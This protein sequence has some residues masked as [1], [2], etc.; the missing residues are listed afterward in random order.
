MDAD[1]LS[2]YELRRCP[3]SAWPDA[4][5]RRATGLDLYVA[6]GARMGS[7]TW[8]GANM[9]SDRPESHLTAGENQPAY[10]FCGLYGIVASRRG[11]H[12]ARV[13]VSERRHGGG[14]RLLPR[15]TLAISGHRNGR[16]AW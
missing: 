15:G 7:R 16:R 1:L 10:R 14:F 11:S 5:A 3:L 4:E 2:A 13:R 8:T 9:G 12:A 6:L